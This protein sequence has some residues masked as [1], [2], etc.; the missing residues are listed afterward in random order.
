MQARVCELQ[1]GILKLIESQLL[2][3]QMTKKDHFKFAFFVQVKER[4]D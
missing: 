1:T 3:L 4:M 2:L